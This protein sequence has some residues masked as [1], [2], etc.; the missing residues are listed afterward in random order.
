MRWIVVPAVVI[1]LSTGCSSVV[2]GTPVADPL[3]L[4]TVTSSAA[5]QRMCA[6]VAPPMT[7]IA[8]KGAD[9]PQL[10]I[11]QPGGWERRTG[12]DSDLIRFAMVNSGLA[13]DGIAA[14][15]VVGLKR[16]EPGM[17]SAGEILDFERQSLEY[18]LGA[19]GVTL[20]KLTHCGFPAAIID[21]Q[22][23]T[24]NKTPPHPGRSLI[25]VVD[26]GPRTWVST[27]TMQTM[28]A[29]NPTYTT[30]SEEIIQGFAVKVP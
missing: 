29:A 28:D 5:P 25:V 9:E 19:T 4:P 27:V 11:P 17:S 13:V 15:A 23:P 18:E 12:L 8:T 3:A 7:A 21:Y 20:D 22:I 2:T 14:T 24:I 30:D 1:A 6:Q 26:V 10:S 16:A